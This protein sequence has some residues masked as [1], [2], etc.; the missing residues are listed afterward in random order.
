MTQIKESAK[1]KCEITK[2]ENESG[3]I[4]EIVPETAIKEKEFIQT[5]IR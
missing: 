3:T 2:E 4:L 1:I 5:R